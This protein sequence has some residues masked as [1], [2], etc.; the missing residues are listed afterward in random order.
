MKKRIF[1]ILCHNETIL[2]QSLLQKCQVIYTGLILLISSSLCTS[3]TENSKILNFDGGKLDASISIASSVFYGIGGRASNLAGSISSF[4]PQAATTLWNPAGAAWLTKG[5]ISLDITPPLQTEASQFIDINSEVK[6]STIEGISAYRTDETVTNPT[7]VGLK[8]SQLGS[9]A[10][11]SIAIPIRDVV[12]HASFYR[13]IDFALDVLFTG[14]KTKIMTSIPMSDKEEE[15]IFNSFIEGPFTGH[16][17]VSTVS[18]GLA[19]KIN[20]VMALGLSIQNY[21]AVF[22]ANSLME[23]NGTMLFAGQEKAFNDPRDLWSNNLHQRIDANFKGNSWGYKLGYT[24]RPNQDLSLDAVF[25]WAFGIVTSG[26]MNLEMNT[27]PA[28]NVDP[29]VS[30]TEEILDP[31]KLDLSMLTYTQPVYNKAYSELKINLPKNLRFGVAYRLG[32]LE[33]HLS[34][35]RYFHEFSFEYGGGRIG[36][37]LKNTLRLGLS[38]KY[39]QLDLDSL[40]LKRFW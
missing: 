27:V 22:G 31:A 8:F 17:G 11:G 33:G 7:N 12:L 6:Q 32:S 3:Q 37:K 18:I 9:I 26:E 23:V 35:G 4:A 24:Y 40:V 21:S 14:F 25:S 28:L 19:S 39:L 30:N 20:K 15:V 1:N 2:Y 38:Y 13:P 29:N 34:Y 10:S 16:F 36:L 5:S